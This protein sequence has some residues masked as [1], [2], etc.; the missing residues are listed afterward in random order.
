MRLITTAILSIICSQTFASLPKPV[1]LKV[2]DGFTNPIGYS[3]E[4]MSFSWKLPQGDGVKQ[5]A[6]RIQAVS[7]A[8]HFDLNEVDLDRI[9][10]WDSGKVES[11]AKNDP[12]CRKNAFTGA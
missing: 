11:S 1:D 12:C 3:L 10:A 4:N 5:S 6:Y 9:R 7:D 8:G 2:A